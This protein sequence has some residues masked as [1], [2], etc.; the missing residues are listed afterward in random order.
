MTSLWCDFNVL[1]IFKLVTELRSLQNYPQG[2]MCMAIV[3]IL[4]PVNLMTKRNIVA[5]T[6]FTLAGTTSNVY[7]SKLTSNGIVCALAATVNISFPAIVGLSSVPFS[8]NRKEK[9]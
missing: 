9:S 5:Y 8:S 1:Q 3:A 4:N 2:H 6:F 7:M